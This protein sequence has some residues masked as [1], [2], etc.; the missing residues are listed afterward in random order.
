VREEQ[1]HRDQ[2]AEVADAVDDERLLSGVGVGL[3][4]EPEPDEQVRAEPHAFPSHEQHGI[5]GPQHEDEHEEDEEVEVREV[6]RITRILPHVAHAEHV[7]QRT[8]SGDHQRHHHRSWS[9]QR[10]IDV[11]VAGRNQVNSV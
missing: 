2:K 6:P 3:V 8:D 4:A 5:A 10:G 1:E 9:L 11:Q 7:D